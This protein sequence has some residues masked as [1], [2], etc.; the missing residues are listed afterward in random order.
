MEANKGHHADLIGV[1]TY[2]FKSVKPNCFIQDETGGIFVNSLPYYLEPGTFVKLTGE[3]VEGW[4]APDIK[5][6]AEITILG[7]RLLPEPSN[8]SPHYL[9][10][11]KRRR[12]VGRG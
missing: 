10:T 8:A 11:G 7:K 2:C 5:A 1:I 6:G 3:T 9:L 12:T 4:F